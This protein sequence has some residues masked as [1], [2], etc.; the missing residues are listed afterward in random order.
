[1]NTNEN[2]TVIENAEAI[3]VVE[4]SAPTGKVKEELVEGTKLHKVVR[5]LADEIKQSVVA[6]DDNTSK[7]GDSVISNFLESRGVSKDVQA[8]Y[9]EAYGVIYPAAKLANAEL[10]IEKMGTDKEMKSFS[11]TIPTIGDDHLYT[12]TTRSQVIGGRTVF[13]VTKLT[14]ETVGQRGVGQMAIVKDIISQRAND[15]LANV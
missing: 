13:G 5:N 2:T 7:A 9:S 1:M 4:T 6:N 8:K 15:A 14:H 10:A 11:T 12:S 3:I